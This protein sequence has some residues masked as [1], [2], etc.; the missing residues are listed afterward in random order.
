MKRA[1]LLLAVTLCFL[2]SNAQSLSRKVFLGIYMDT[3]TDE[4]MRVAKLKKQ[5]GILISKI[6]PGSTSEAAGLQKGD[7]LIRM[8]DSTIGSIAQVFRLLKN[9]HEGDRLTYSVNRQGKVL[10]RSLIVKGLPK[11][12][13]SDL[14]VSYGEVRSKGNQL[15]TIVTKEPTEA[16]RPAVLFVPGIGCYS[17]DS[18]LDTNRSETQLVNHLARKG[19][20]VMR[21]DKSGMGDS[22]GTPCGLLDFN[23]E[24]DGYKEALNALKKMPDVDTARCFIIGHSMGGVMAPVI[25]REV[26][27]R[28]IIAYGTIGVNFMQY[29][30]DTRKTLADA[31][32][33]TDSEK[34]DYV[35]EQC[36]CAGLLFSAHLK[37][38]E[39][40]KINP[41]CKE[42]IDILLLRDYPY[43]EQLTGI[44]IPAMWQSYT[45]KVL[46]LWG[47]A[48]FI[49]SPE[50]HKHIVNVVNKY[51][52]GNALFKEVPNASHGMQVAGSFHE[53]LEDTNFFNT[54]V[55]AIMSE[56]LKQQTN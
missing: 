10:S 40:L 56:W 33:M 23:T 3:V 28:G 46:A 45:G 37:R 22:K 15:R 50:E 32:E 2:I 39:I 42:V 12:K 1:F 35:K 43:W 26:S 55:A 54:D 20:I 53:G 49:S 13:Y 14:T 48:D 36:Q 5:E 34:D 21:V 4:A 47:S 11:E 27:I 24:M 52:A 18:P 30:A 29:W 25:A 41:N 6:I 17:T 51:H 7:I 9:V 44:N 19:F 16:K 31:Y 8:A 38:E